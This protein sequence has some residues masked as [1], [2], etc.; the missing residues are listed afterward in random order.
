MTALYCALIGLGAG[1]C[2]G[3]FGIGGGIVIVP[4]L[5]YIMGFG[6]QRAQGTSLMMLMLPV[7]ALSVMN[8]AKEKQVDFIAA[9]WIAI[10]FFL[11]GYLGSKIALNMDEG[12]LRKAF[13][14]FLVLIA[15]QLWFRK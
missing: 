3:L 6:Q 13:S 14:G 15:V 4:A 5:I 12:I 8:Y 10:G 11:G 7:A 1:I 2:G 9:G